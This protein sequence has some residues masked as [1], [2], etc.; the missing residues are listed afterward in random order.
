MCANRQ[1]GLNVQTT[2]A[3]LLDRWKERK[4]ISSDYEAA[5]AL[6]VSRASLSNWRK[7]TNHADVIA[8]ATMAEDLGMETIEILAAIQADREIRPQAQAIWR[9]YG[10]PAFFALIACAAIPISAPGD[11]LGNVKNAHYDTAAKCETRQHNSLLCEVIRGTITERK[12]NRWRRLA[13]MIR[14]L[15]LLAR[16]HCVPGRFTPGTLLT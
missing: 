5:R 6:G 12:I 4:G 10:R 11:A 15:W 2:T 9:R 14:R 16:A 13:A 1:E 7:G 8:A 3:L